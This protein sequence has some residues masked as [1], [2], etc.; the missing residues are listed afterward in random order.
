MTRTLDLGPAEE[1]RLRQSP[2]LQARFHAWEAWDS[3]LAKA[4]LDLCAPALLAQ[5][6]LSHLQGRHL[7]QL[8]SGE[9][10]KARI[11]VALSE[12]PGQLI[13]KNPYA[14][15]DP[16]SREAL[17]A[18]LGGLENISVTEDGAGPALSAFRLSGSPWLDP[19]APASI[20][21]LQGLR[22]AYDGLLLFENLDWEIM[23]G[24][25][26]RLKGP[27]GSGK[28]S[29]LALLQGD[30]PQAY[31]GG[32]SLFGRARG[33]GESIWELKARIGALSPELHAFFPAGLSVRDSL[34]SGFFDSLG[35]FRRPSPAH[36][37]A[38]D[39]WLM[40]AGLKH[41]EGEPFGGLSF[42]Q[43][44]LLLFFR[45]L[46]KRPALLLLDEP[47]QGLNDAEAA[48][49]LQAIGQI[50]GRSEGALVF[51]GHREDQL[52]PGLNQSMALPGP[53]AI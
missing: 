47:C 9:F 35:L 19:R 4:W 36:E 50:A 48:R 14:G 30:H 5:L 52:P 13:L 25:R 22:I 33:S 39:E 46:I 6:G 42:F 40:S 32:L 51:C 16:S 49:L 15:P 24:S 1:A 21:S 26:W 29:L 11:A 45:A 20:A 44:R 34:L 37:A 2:Y 28:T 41:L 43:Q 31:A 12:N 10:R 38:A 17:T 27:N 18:I 23:S 53:A 3:P 7:S 8:S